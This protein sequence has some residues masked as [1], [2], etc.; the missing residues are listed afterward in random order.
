MEQTFG[1]LDPA[2]Q[3][4]GQRLDEI[5]RTVAQVKLDQKMI[6]PLVEGGPGDAIEMPLVRKVFA[7]S[8]FLVE[9]GRLENDTDSSAQGSG[10]LQQIEPQN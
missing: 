7:H 2:L 6:D 5:A 9:A 10:V 1:D 4:A 3:S 8:Q